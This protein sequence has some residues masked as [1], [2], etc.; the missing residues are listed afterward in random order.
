V[1]FDRLEGEVLKVAIAGLVES[2]QNRHSLAQ[3]QVATSCSPALTTIEQTTLPPR[4]EPLAEVI[5]VAGQVF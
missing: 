1:L 5:D 3:A 4:F 2:H